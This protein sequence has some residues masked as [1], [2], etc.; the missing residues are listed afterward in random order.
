[1]NAVTNPMTL[2]YSE[3]V[4]E[5]LKPIS[6]RR[7]AG[8]DLSFSSLFDDIREARRADESGLAQGAWEAEIKSADWNRVRVLCE[9]AL[10]GRTKDLQLAAWYVEARVH[11]EGF[12]GLVAGLELFHGLLVNHWDHCHPPADESLDERAGKIAWLNTQ[13]PLAIKKIPVTDGKNHGYSWL[14][15]QESRWVENLGQK[16]AEAK[17]LAISDGKLSAELF[18]KAA[19]Q[20]DRRFGKALASD[21]RHAMMWLQAVIEVVD[22]AFGHD[23]PSLIDLRQ[24]LHDCGMLIDRL[25]GESKVNTGNGHIESLSSAQW[26]ASPNAISGN[27]VAAEDIGTAGVL[28]NRAA[29]IQSLRDVAHY[30]RL[31]EPHSPVAL[32]AERAARWA[33]MPMEEWLSA[34]IKDD[35]TL[36]QLRELLD[37]SV[38]D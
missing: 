31:N 36:S 38:S 6:D 17:A 24:A 1:M 25:Y 30:F 16:D 21:A 10:S 29:A 23:A 35:A 37:I 14:Q 18:D 26:Q 20:S 32:L 12:A 27:A 5:L 4:S 3:M 19:L 8:E 22:N 9:S 15:W 7:P 34:V 28:N 2:N 11:L 33:E 13:L